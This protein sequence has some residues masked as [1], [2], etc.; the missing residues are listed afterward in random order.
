MG[1]PT[2]A[3]TAKTPAPTN[4]PKPTKTPAPTSGSFC[5]KL[6]SKGQ[7]KKQSEKCEWWNGGKVKCIA[8]G[9]KD[10]PAPTEKGGKSKYMET[11]KTFQAW[12]KKNNDSKNSLCRSDVGCG[13]MKKDKKDKDKDGD[14]KDKYCKWA[15]KGKKVKCKKL[16]PFK[17][18]GETINHCL[19]VPGCSWDGKKCNGKTDKKW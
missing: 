18:E 13:K 17:F 6:T 3:P 5:G 15:T 14:T 10:T 9:S 12:C 2:N 16:K 1:A 4:T 19:K 7:C 11:F 8:K